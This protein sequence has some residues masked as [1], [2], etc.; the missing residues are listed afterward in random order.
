MDSG[1]V[2]GLGLALLNGAIC[3]MLPLW[4]SGRDRAVVVAD[5]VRADV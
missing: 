4:I 1:F 2:L 3:L 5:P